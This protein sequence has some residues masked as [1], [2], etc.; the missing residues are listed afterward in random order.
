M[1]QLPI[2]RTC[3]VLCSSWYLKY[4]SNPS[5]LSEANLIWK[6]PQ[7]ILLIFCVPSLDSS[8]KFCKLFP[9]FLRCSPCS[10]SIF[11]LFIKWCFFMVQ[12]W[13]PGSMYWELNEEQHKEE[14]FYYIV[15]RQSD[16]FSSLLLTFTIMVLLKLI[17]MCFGKY[18]RVFTLC[19]DWIFCVLRGRET[20]RQTGRQAEMCSVVWWYLLEK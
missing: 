10:F 8:S 20:E 16:L 15:Y 17:K 13:N 6:S 9:L 12:R 5:Y 11:F 3:W 14:M 18:R 1:W 4:I 19:T 2:S 7:T